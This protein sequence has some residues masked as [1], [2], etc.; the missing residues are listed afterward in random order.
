MKEI[1]I[2]LIT[3]LPTMATLIVT[4]IVNSKVKKQNDLRQEMTDCQNQIKDKLDKL[5]NKINENRKKALRNILVNDYTDLIKGKKK[6]KEQLQNI[7]DMYEEY[8]DELDGDSYVEDLHDIAK[9]KLGDILKWVIK[10]MIL[11][12]I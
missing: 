8:H 4:T 12:K 1:I 9:E 7:A 11:L 5:E 6:T 2:A 3:I 10:F